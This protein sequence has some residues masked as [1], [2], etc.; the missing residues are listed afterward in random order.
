MLLA[1]PG[2]GAAVSGSWEL[3]VGNRARVRTC[4]GAIVTGSVG[5]SAGAGVKALC[6]V[7]G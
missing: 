7:K 5:V 6:R 1:C 3:G 4:C 2:A